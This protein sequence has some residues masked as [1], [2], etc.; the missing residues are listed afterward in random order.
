MDL[1]EV[2]YEGVNCIHLTQSR[3][4]MTW[5]ATIDFSR[6]LSVMHGVNSLLSTLIVPQLLLDPFEQPCNL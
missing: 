3:E 6:G 4:N 2:V 1:K 5:R